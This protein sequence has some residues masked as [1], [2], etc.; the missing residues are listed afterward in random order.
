MKV[1]LLGSVKRVPL[2]RKTPAHQSMVVGGCFS[3]G[4]EVGRL[5]DQER[6]TF[7]HV[8]AKAPRLHQ[9]GEAYVPL[10]D[11]VGL[12]EANGACTGP[13][14]QAVHDEG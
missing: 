10:G 1:V 4:Q 7:R 3:L 11:R 13:L 9:G 5:R 8:D 12:V 14:L 2:K 6:P